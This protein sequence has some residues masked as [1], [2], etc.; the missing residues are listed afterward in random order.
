MLQA[1]P[2]ATK[3]VRFC[4]YNAHGSHAGKRKDSYIGF[5]QILIRGGFRK[6]DLRQHGTSFAP[7]LN[8]LK[9]SGGN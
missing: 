8:I 4:I 3:N 2:L 6:C 7:A 9:I 5:D 1:S